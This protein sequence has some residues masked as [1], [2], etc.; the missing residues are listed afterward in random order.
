MVRDASVGRNS[1]SRVDSLKHVGEMKSLVY[2]QIHMTSIT[3][4]GL[5]RAEL[6]NRRPLTKTWPIRR[7][8][9]TQSHLGAKR[10]S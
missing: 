4:E 10:V 2:L 3:D 6:Q 1:R 8:G 7:I 9:S 5:S